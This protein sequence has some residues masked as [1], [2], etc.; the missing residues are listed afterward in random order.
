MPLFELRRTLGFV[1]EGTTLFGRPS[2]AIPTTHLG[3]GQGCEL[4]TSSAHLES[5][6]I[7]VDI[8]LTGRGAASARTR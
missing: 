7:I 6:S 2:Q 4:F 8:S 3:K 1:G 5:R